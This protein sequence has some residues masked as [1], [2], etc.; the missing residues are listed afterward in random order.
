MGIFLSM[1]LLAQENMR[2]LTSGSPILSSSVLRGTAAL[3]WPLIYHMGG[4]ADTILPLGQMSISFLIAGN[5]AVAS[6]ILLGSAPIVGRR[7]G[8]MC[9]AS[10]GAQNMA[11]ESS[12]I[13]TPLPYPPLLAQ[14]YPL[15]ASPCLEIASCLISDVFLAP[16]L[17]LLV[18]QVPPTYFMAH[19]QH[20]EP[21]VHTYAGAGELRIE[22]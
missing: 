4:E 5:L 21:A 17:V 9:R 2:A 6:M 20:S 22:F 15:S 19:L 3:K 16:V 12:A 1:W 14:F 8:D 10:Q 18:F 13:S 11:E 7:R